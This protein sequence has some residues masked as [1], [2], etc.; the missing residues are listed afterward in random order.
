MLTMAIGHYQ[1]NAMVS[2][3]TL[4]PK[5]KVYGETTPWLDKVINYRVS[6]TATTLRPRLTATLW[7]HNEMTKESTHTHT[8]WQLRMLTTVM[9]LPQ[10]YMIKKAIT[11]NKDVDCTNYIGF[12]MAES[13]AM[14]A[15]KQW[16]WA[17]CRSWGGVL[18]DSAI[19]F[20]DIEKER[21]KEQ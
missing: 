21:Q 16:F 14:G 12:S 8:S 18:S 2:K 4:G 9:V 10:Q 5:R 1:Y 20:L 3:N 15:Q 6:W 13:V 19:S 7:F 11:N 17:P